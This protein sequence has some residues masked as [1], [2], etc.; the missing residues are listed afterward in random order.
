[1]CVTC[2]EPVQAA[3]PTA[4][5]PT[6]ASE[7]GA[8]NTNSNPNRNLNPDPNPFFSPSPNSIPS[9]N[10]NSNPNPNP[11][12][13]HYPFRNVGIAVVG[14]VANSR[15]EQG[16]VYAPRSVDDES[17][18]SECTEGCTRVCVCVCA[19]QEMIACGSPAPRPAGC[20]VSSAPVS[21]CAA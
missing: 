11:N 9:P 5:I 21:L 19:Q 10:P 13:L 20:K 8:T 14:I 1:V 16:S 15:L 12:P 18:E 3:I 17:S 2:L 7:K 4:A 6:N